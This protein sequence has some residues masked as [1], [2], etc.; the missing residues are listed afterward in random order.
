MCRLSINSGS[1]N[2]LEP[3]EPTQACIRF[4]LPFLSLHFTV[5]WISSGVGGGSGIDQRSK[6]NFGRCW[7]STVCTEAGLQ[8]ARTGVWIPAAKSD[9]FLLQMVWTGPG[10][11]HCHLFSVKQGFFLVGAKRSERDVDHCYLAPSFRMTV[12]LPLLL[13]YV[14]MSWTTNFSL[15]HSKGEEN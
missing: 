1:F 12:I 7:V 2:F 5:E 9:I 8:A 6:W 10:G 11:P 13:L 4:A 14:F 15:Y 3:K